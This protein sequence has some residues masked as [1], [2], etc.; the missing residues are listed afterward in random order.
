MLMSF[1]ECFD[2]GCHQCGCQ[3]FSYLCRSLLYPSLLCLLVC[4]DFH[5]RHGLRSL[6]NCQSSECM[7]MDVCDLLN[8]RCNISKAS[9][10]PACTDKHRQAW[11]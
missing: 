4:A 10:Q 9:A 6:Q 11:A 8:C 5:M 1:S 7:W 3:V 2:R